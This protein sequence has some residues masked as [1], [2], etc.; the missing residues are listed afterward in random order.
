M[1]WS[2]LYA[3]IMNSILLP[4]INE[5]TSTKTSPQPSIPDEKKNKNKNKIQPQKLDSIDSKDLQNF[6]TP[7]T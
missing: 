2:V 7:Y 5:L 3:I 4:K 6:W 1:K